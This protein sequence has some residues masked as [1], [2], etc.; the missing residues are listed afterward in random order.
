MVRAIVDPFNNLIEADE[1]NNYIR[2][3]IVLGVNEYPADALDAA[4]IKELQLGVGD[5]QLS[6]LSVHQPGD[7][8]TFRWVAASDG[9]FDVDL[10]F[11]HAEGDIDLYVWGT[12]AAGKVQLLS[13]VTEANGEHVTM[14]IT[15]GKSYV[16]VVKDLSGDTN[17]SYSLSVNGPDILPDY[18]EPNDSVL[19]PTDLDRASMTLSNLTIHAPTDRDFFTWTAPETATLLVD[20]QFN[21]VQGN[22]DLIVHDFANNLVASSSSNIGR[23]LLEVDVQEGQ[24]YLII[25]QGRNGDMVNRY[26]LTVDLLNIPLDNFEPNDAYS[27]P[28]RLSAGDQD[29]DGLTIHKPFNRDFY[30]W[31]AS[32]DGTAVVDLLF[33]QA[34]GDLDLVLWQGSESVAWSTSTTDNERLTFD[35]VGGYTYLFEVLGKN[36]ATNSSYRMTVDGPDAIADALEPDDSPMMATDLGRDDVESLIGNIHASFNSDFYQWTPIANGVAIIDVLFHQIQGD[37]DVV[38]WADG[39]ALETAATSDD[40]E[41][42]FRYVDAGQTYIL[43]VRGKDGDIN[44]FYELRIDGP[45]LVADAFEPN[46]T[47]T[48]AVDLGAGDRQLTDLSVHVA[49][50]SDFYRWSPVALG[51][52]TIDLLFAQDRG[53]LDL[54]LWVD[55]NETYIGES[56]DDNEHLDFDAQLGHQYVI[57]VRGKADAV[58]PFYEL[59]VDGPAAPQVVDVEVARTS[60]PQQWYGVPR[61]DAEEATIPWTDWQQIRLTFSADVLVQVGDLRIVDAED[62]DQ[63]VQDFLYDATERRATWT[64]ASSPP[65]GP[66]VLTL[67]DNVQDRLLNPLDGDTSGFQLPSGDGS[68]GGNWVLPIH[69][70]PGDLHADGQLNN[71][72]LDALAAAIQTSDPAGDLNNDGTTSSDDIATLVRELMGTDIGDVNLDGRF[73]S[74]DLIIMFIAGQFEDQRVGNSRWSTGDL[75]GDAEFDS[76]DLIFAFQFGG[77][78]P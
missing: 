2:H 9:Q 27:E 23:E 71:L 68:P 47:L 53:D 74:T 29:L 33:A 56:A 35:V 31:Q 40:N 34:D 8:D 39:T 41:R 14:P 51:P 73:D 49:G 26:N 43:E 78:Q 72:D 28:V 54:A 11:D 15:G 69:V 75:D 22:L 32:A 19:T 52:A 6:Q 20:L 70:L 55:G 4:G 46:D 61:S 59:Q 25:V 76:S 7:I 21:S 36:G 30:R 18:L 13:S 62:A 10:T 60:S 63:T 37:L 12:N 1:S 58:N 50:N 66:L 57:E 42:V 45:E 44:P 64:L 16:I 65:T 77:Y 38:L 24:T 5:R 17:P 67:S 3:K 48:T